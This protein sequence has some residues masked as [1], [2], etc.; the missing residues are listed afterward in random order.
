MSKGTAN[1]SDLEMVTS[2]RWFEKLIGNYF[3]RNN[4]L[5]ISWIIWIDK[6]INI[7]C[8]YRINWEEYYL[9]NTKHPNKNSYSRLQYLKHY[10]KNTKYRK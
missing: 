10:N 5:I 2:S 7:D 6:N 1:C 9:K 4:R 3:N 8:K